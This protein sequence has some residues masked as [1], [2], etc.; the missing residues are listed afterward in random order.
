MSIFDPDDFAETLA[1]SIDI[2][3]GLF[4]K[5]G[6]TRVE[7]SI[8]VAGYHFVVTV[9]NT[10]AASIELFFDNCQ[11]T[12]VFSSSD[13]CTVPGPGAGIGENY[14][15]VGHATVNPDLYYQH[16]TYDGLDIAQIEIGSECS[17]GRMINNYRYD[18]LHRVINMD[19][20]LFTPDPYSDAFS[21]SY[22]YDKA[23]NILS[24]SRNGFVGLDST[25]MEPIYVPIDQ[26]SYTYSGGTSSILSSVIDSLPDPDHLP[27]GVDAPP[28][29]P[30][31]FGYDANGNAFGNGVTQYNMLNLPMSLASVNGTAQQDYVLT[32]Q[33]YRKITEDLTTGEESTRYYLSGVEWVD[34]IP[35]TYFFGDGRLAWEMDNDTLVGWTQYRITDHLGNSMVFFD[36]KDENG[37]LITEETA[38]PTG[39]LEVKQ[40]LWYYPFGMQMEGI[41][42]QNADPAQAYR[43]NGKELDE[44]TGLYDYGARYYDPAIARWGQVDPL[45]D[46]YAPYSPYNY[47][48]GN[49]I[50]LIDPDGQ[51]VIIPSFGKNQILRNLAKIVAADHGSNTVRALISSHSSYRISRIFWTNSSGYDW[52]GAEGP[53]GVIRAPNR[54]WQPTVDGAAND[55]HYV[56]FHEVYHAYSHELARQ[57]VFPREPR[58]PSR[59]V[60]EGSAVTN[61]NKLRAIYGETLMRTSYFGMPG[62]TFS[63]DPN[64]YNPEGL[65]ISN[66]VFDD[67]RAVGNST[68]QGFHYDYRDADGVTSTKYGVIWSTPDDSGN[69]VV[70][71]KRFSSKGDYE[72]FISSFE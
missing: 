57:R 66:F 72:G 4:G 5:H 19:N 50:R 69:N 53:R 3:L 59:V 10:D 54:T 39:P 9:E 61:T 55:H 14:G 21:T 28:T 6:N 8:T 34:S 38:N 43:Y 42:Q 23:G 62:L 44:A 31:A 52:S 49:P 11:D 22:T 68:I 46:Q 20:I 27:F 48:L 2:A 67:I 24:L 13:C 26:L 16:M 64:T 47:V 70:D 40:R 37:I 36:D 45:A 58:E 1:E 12:F 18:P 32:G 30:L 51:K 41:G 7:S 60:L 25:T 17:Y 29:A 71:F 63:D 33:K 56:L 15:L 65:N 35:Q